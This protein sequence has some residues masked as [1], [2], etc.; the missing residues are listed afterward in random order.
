VQ[1]DSKINRKE[2]R[3]Y[4]NLLY[5]SKARKTDYFLV[6]D[7]GNYTLIPCGTHS[8]HHIHPVFHIMFVTDGSGYLENDQGRHSVKPKDIFLINPN[9]KHILS[10]DDEKGMTY[11]SFNFYLIPS[12]RHEF[13]INNDEWEIGQRT[14]HFNELICSCAETLK[15]NEIFPIKL[16]GIFIQYDRSYWNKI[17]SLISNL[18]GTMEEYYISLIHHWRTKQALWNRQV[19]IDGFAGFFWDIC[20]IFNLT[21]D[22]HEKEKVNDHLL[23]SII[24]Y[25]QNHI[26]EKYSLSGL[27]DHLNYNP[28]YLCSYFK[29]NTGMTISQYFNKLKIHRSCLYLRTT[30]RSIT[31]IANML[32]FSSPNHFS[33]IFRQE[34]GISPKDY[35]K[36]I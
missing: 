16:S 29:K 28:A 25:L 4:M 11:F 36:Q 30:G 13:F 14:G 18:S 6:P 33:T 1:E 19:C 5:Y 24:D 10:S 35:R 22:R 26:H 15:I 34:K 32:N 2:Q 9:E 21:D 23:N 27:S 7:R 31:E 17:L 8:D 20:R 12:G 3:I